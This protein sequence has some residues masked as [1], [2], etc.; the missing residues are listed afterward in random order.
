MKKKCNKCEI[1]KCLAEFSKGRGLYQKHSWCIKCQSQYHQ[2]RKSGVIKPL[3]VRACPYR[4]NSLE[5]DIWVHFYRFSIYLSNPKVQSIL[6]RL[7]NEKTNKLKCLAGIEEELGC[8]QENYN[9][10]GLRDK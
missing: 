2:E 8:H 4:Q 9:I 10:T 7:K 6:E 1:Q 3:E 5:Y